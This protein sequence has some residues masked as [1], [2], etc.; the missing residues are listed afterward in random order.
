VN[1][2]R[3][4]V[5]QMLADGKITVA[6]AETLLQALEPGEA[7]SRQPEPAPPGRP[8]K[9]GDLVQQ[10]LAEADRALDDAVRSVE[11]R[12]AAQEQR[13]PY[14]KIRELSRSIERAGE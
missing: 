7:G 5:L 9:L 11:E 3:Q 14:R 13:E 12:L 2:E 4:L 1:E 6:E 10:A 8:R